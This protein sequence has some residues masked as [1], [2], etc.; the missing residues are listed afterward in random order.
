MAKAKGVRVP[1]IE[2]PEKAQRMAD[3]IKLLRAYLTGW[4][5][6]G[7]VMPPGYEVLWQ[8]HNALR[9]VK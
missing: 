6:A 2:T 9:N 8:I 5:E 4:K 1:D 7:R 3:Q